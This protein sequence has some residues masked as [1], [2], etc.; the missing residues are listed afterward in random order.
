MLEAIVIDPFLNSY[1]MNFETEADPYNLKIRVDPAALSSAYKKT[2]ETS[3]T[4]HYDAE[5]TVFSKYI[6][7]RCQR[8]TK[9]SSFD[10]TVT[11]KDQDKLAEDIENS[12]V[13]ERYFDNYL[14]ATAYTL[15]QTR[16]NAKLITLAR[17]CKTAPSVITKYYITLFY[18]YTDGTLDDTTKKPILKSKQIKVIPIDSTIRD[19]T[20]IINSKVDGVTPGLIKLISTQKI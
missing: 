8:N 1:A 11:I 18:I 6:Q 13:S 7:A 3:N 12:F 5:H 20:L 9:D 17:R 19:T 4:F 10:I 15:F 16:R 14:Y 2:K